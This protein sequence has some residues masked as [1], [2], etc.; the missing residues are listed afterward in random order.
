MVTYP[1]VRQRVS[2][3]ASC[4]LI[5][6]GLTTLI[7]VPVVVYALYRPERWPPTALLAAAWWTYWLT[8]GVVS[9]LDRKF[10]N[11]RRQMMVVPPTERTLKNFV[12]HERASELYLGLHNCALIFGV[13]TGVAALLMG[14]SV[15]LAICFVIF[16]GL[17]VL[18]IVSFFEFDRWYMLQQEE[19]EKRVRNLSRMHKSSRA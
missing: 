9:Y 14:A 4:S 16:S 11:S 17:I 7:A 19:D 8:W 13:P 3:I 18:L 15:P 10:C 1:E 6:I 12:R 2:K 5:A